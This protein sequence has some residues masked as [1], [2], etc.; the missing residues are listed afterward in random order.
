MMLGHGLR[1]ALREGR[2]ANW[3]HDFARASDVLAVPGDRRPLLGGLADLGAF[4][5]GA[6]RQGTSVREAATRDI[7]WDGEA[8]AT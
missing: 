4:A 5:I 7:E 1:R 3:R 2:F 8:I 6:L